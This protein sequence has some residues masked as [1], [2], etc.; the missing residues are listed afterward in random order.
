MDTAKLL[1]RLTL[2][3][4]LAPLA[5]G[6]GIVATWWVTRWD[7]LAIAGLFTILGGTLL[8]IA[9]AL[10]LIGYLVL[11]FRHGDRWQAALRAVVAAFV[12]M[13]PFPTALAIIAAVEREM[14]PPRFS[15]LNSGSQIDGFVI[16]D[17]TAKIDVGPIPSGATHYGHLWPATGQR[18]E[19][20][21]SRDGEEISGIVTERLRHAH[22][23]FVIAFAADGTWTVEEQ[24]DRD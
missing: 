23:N 12:L 21:A 5:I 15:V 13:A 14:F 20:H 9:G 18:V 1:Y 7:W 6:I 24:P 8:V 3:C 2:I 17:K 22:S 19:F 10:L 11:A 4:G 16:S